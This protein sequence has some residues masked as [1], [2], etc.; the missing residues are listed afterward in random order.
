MSDRG[1]CRALLSQEEPQ[2]SAH[3]K[4]VLRTQL[5]PPTEGSDNTGESCTRI[6]TDG[7]NGV[8]R[9]H[10]RRCHAAVQHRVSIK[11]IFSRI[12]MTS[13]LSQGADS[14]EGGVMPV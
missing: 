10:K 13:T 3:L 9:R 1:M 6:P 11:T 5:I 14:K 4:F 2:R 7:G 12:T 8:V